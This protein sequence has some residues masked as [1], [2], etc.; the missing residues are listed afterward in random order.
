MDDFAGLKKLNPKLTVE[1]AE[2]QSNL[3]QRIFKSLRN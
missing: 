1:K 2:N 3:P